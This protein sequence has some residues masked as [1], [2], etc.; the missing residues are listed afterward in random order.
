MMHRYAGG[1]QL[2]FQ[3]DQ[4]VRMDNSL[5][6]GRRHATLRS[7][8]RIVAQSPLRAAEFQDSYMRTKNALV[9]WL[10]LHTQ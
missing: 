1:I 3:H 4:L 2:D 9:V 8:I 10:H 7:I 6:N 5:R